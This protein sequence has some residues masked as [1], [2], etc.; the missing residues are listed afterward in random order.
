MLSKSCKTD[1]ANT[2]K[3]R[4]DLG[5]ILCVHFWSQNRPKIQ[6]KSMP[7]WMQNLIASW[8]RFLVDFGPFW[9]PYGGPF[10]TLLGDFLQ[11]F[12]HVSFKVKKKHL[13]GARRVGSMASLGGSKKLLN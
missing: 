10:G 9:L 4:S 12:L 13:P 11:S 7:E 3:R 5:A 1:F 2:C 8:R 6:Q